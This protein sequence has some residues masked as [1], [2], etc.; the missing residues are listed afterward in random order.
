MDKKFLAKALRNPIY[1][2]AIRHK[3]GV[4]QHEPIITRQLCD[5]MQ[6][7]L[8]DD[9]HDRMGATRNKTDTLLRGLLYGTNG[10]KYR[11]TFTTKP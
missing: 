7:I 1:V 11:I 4:G 8:A 2:G 5:Q 10:E 3:G 6:A 9:T